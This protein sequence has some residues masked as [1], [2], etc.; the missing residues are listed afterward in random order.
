MAGDWWI[1]IVPAGGPPDY[2]RSST[3]FAVGYQIITATLTGGE[4]SYIVTNSTIS[5]DSS[6]DAMKPGG[7]DMKIIVYL[8]K[9]T[10]LDKV[11]D[12]R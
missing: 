5:T 11:I 10:V 8:F 1:S 9:S 2:R 6:A 4:G 7:Y 12:V 3:D